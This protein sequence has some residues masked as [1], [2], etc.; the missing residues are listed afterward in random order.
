MSIRFV[1]MLFLIVALS[2]ALGNYQPLNG[3]TVLATLVF[4]AYAADQHFRVRMIPLAA[5]VWLTTTTIAGAYGV[6]RSLYPPE[7][8][9]EW[10]FSP[11]PAGIFTALAVGISV[12]FW[13][14][15]S[16]IVWRVL[17]LGSIQ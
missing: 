11:I 10:L 6:G 15:V 9:G 13:M 8:E 1:L 14:I 3:F 7:M 17:K 12:A 5:F 4:W 2:L 16:C